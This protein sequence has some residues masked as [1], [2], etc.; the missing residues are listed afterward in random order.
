V[1]S[2]TATI[3]KIVNGFWS[4]HYQLGNPFEPYKTIY[5]VAIF[6]SRTIIYFANR[7]PSP[8][9]FGKPTASPAKILRHCFF[10]GYVEST[11]S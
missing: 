10:C 2:S 8:Q 4:G 5:Q 1:P 7:S 6:H 3:G 9:H 11:F